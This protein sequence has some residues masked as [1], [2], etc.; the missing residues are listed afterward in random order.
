MTLT[1]AGMANMTIVNNVFYQPFCTG[2]GTSGGFSPVVFIST[3]FPGMRILG[4]NY[5]RNSNNG[6]ALLQ[7][8]SS[9]FATIADLRAVALE[10][11]GTTNYGGDFFNTNL[12]MQRLRQ[13]VRPQDNSYVDNPANFVGDFVNA[14]SLA[15]NSLNVALDS[16]FNSPGLEVPMVVGD[17]VSTSTNDAY[18]YQL[19][20]PVG[21]K[22]RP[23]C[24]QSQVSL[25]ELAL[26]SL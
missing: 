3:S 17:D 13:I 15:V 20:N 21:Q 10:R 14:F 22:K 1:G 5:V 19:D 25:Q 11:L 18:Q 23:V 26:V 12:I 16:V 7:V 8:S 24:S 4:N 6:C 2:T 9:S